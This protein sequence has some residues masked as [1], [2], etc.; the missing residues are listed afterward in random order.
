MA[1][2]RG[3]HKR[4]SDEAWKDRDLKIGAAEVGTAKT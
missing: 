2:D 4:K 3:L 1:V